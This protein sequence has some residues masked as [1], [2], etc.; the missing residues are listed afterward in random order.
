MLLVLP[1][2]FD[3]N[4]YIGKIRSFTGIFSNHTADKIYNEFDLT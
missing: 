4:N 2:T 1:E 3:L